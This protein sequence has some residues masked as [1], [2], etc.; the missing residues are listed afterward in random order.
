MRYSLPLA[1]LLLSA[2]L[3]AQPRYLVH[4]FAS[5]QIP[6]LI[7]ELASDGRFVRTLQALPANLLPVSVVMGAD[8]AS[9]RVGAT[10]LVR[11]NSGAVFDIDARGYLT[12]VALGGGI[13]W[14][15]GQF[16]T[17][18]GDWLIVNDARSRRQ[19]EVLLLKGSRLSTL[20]VAQDVLC[21]H[22]VGWDPS[23]DAI[24]AL[25]DQ[26]GGRRNYVRIAPSTGRITTIAPYPTVGGYSTTY[27]THT[28]LV[29][30]ENDRVVDALYA[31]NATL[32]LRLDPGFNRL[33]T[34]ARSPAWW[35]PTGLA[36]AGGAAFP[37]HYTLLMRNLP[38]STTLNLT[39][40]RGDGVSVRSAL[41]PTA[42]GL[43]VSSSLT[44]VESRP[45]R[46]FVQTPPNGRYLVLNVPSRPAQP[47]VV[48]LSLS[49]VRPGFVLPDGRFRSAPTV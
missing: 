2:A 32:L 7:R 17:D 5:F 40:I 4:D 46:W 9:Y 11:L 6:V 27:T 47:F 24:V 29:D 10:D 48:L 15:V 18:D 35:A 42:R 49:G 31:Y 3:P 19:V 34:I 28:P 33:T 20:S 12:T 26:L 16:V 44:R 36:K 37:A 43:S 23:R 41:V 21:T 38:I 45:L 8:N 39:H 13:E 14:P 22:S 25:V 30:V 1:V